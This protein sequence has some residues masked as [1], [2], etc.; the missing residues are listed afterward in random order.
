MQPAQ[1][2]SLALEP[3]QVNSKKLAAGL[4]QLV[5]ALAPLMLRH[6]AHKDK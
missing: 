4:H 3:D 5:M 1:V 6:K 2:H